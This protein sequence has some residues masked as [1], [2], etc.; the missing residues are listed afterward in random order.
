MLDQKYCCLLYTSQGRATQV[1]IRSMEQMIGQKL[2][3]DSMKDFTVV[4]ITDKVQPLIYAQPSLFTDMIY[5]S[6]S[7]D[8]QI[9]GDAEPPA[10]KNIYNY[11]TYSGEYEL[12]KG[13][14]PENDY[15]TIVPV[16]YT[17]LLYFSL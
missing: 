17:H 14:L 12:K 11:E 9:Y 8:E 16:S 4:G 15:E 13:R 2:S 3:L 5:N 6:S 10:Q 7:S 1:G